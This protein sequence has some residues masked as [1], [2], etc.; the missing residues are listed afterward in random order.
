MDYNNPLSPWNQHHDDKMYDEMTDEEKMKVGCLHLIVVIL[1]FFVGIGLCCLFGSCTTTKYVTVPEI[2]D[3]H[4]W[5]TD[6]IHQTDSIIKENITTV[7]QLDSSAMAEYGIKLKGAERA[8][9]VKTQEMERQIQML[10]Q[11]NIQKDSVH[12]TVPV[13]VPVIKEVPAELSWWQ[14]LRIHIANILLW[15]LLVVGVWLAVKKFVLHR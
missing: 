11:M 14:Q 4:H 12:D 7:M 15:A 9:L 13:P 10:L 1:M 8:W 2:H 6:S 3:Q 5:H